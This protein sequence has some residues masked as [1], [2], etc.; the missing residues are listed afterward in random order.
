MKDVLVRSQNERIQRIC[1]YWA[2]EESLAGSVDGRFFVVGEL[3]SRL[4]QTE[5][6]PFFGVHRRLHLHTGF[7]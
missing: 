3:R 2:E 7:P 5:M 4:Y 6:D 1:L